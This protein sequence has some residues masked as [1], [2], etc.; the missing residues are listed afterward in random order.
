MSKLQQLKSDRQL[1]QVMHDFMSTYQQ[2]AAHQMETIRDQIIQGR[3][4]LEGLR[5]VFSDVNKSHRREIARLEQ[6]GKVEAAQQ[7]KIVTTTK[8][9][10]S[11]AVIISPDTKFSGGI[12]RRIFDSFKQHINQKNPDHIYVIGTVAR[13]FFVAT[14]P[15]KEF[16]E[17]HLPDSLSNL[18][19]LQPLLEELIQFEQVE[20]FYG[21]FLSLIRQEATHLDL[22]GGQTND[23]TAA[24]EAIPESTSYNRDF[25][26]EPAL[27]TMLRFFEVQIFSTLLLRSHHEAYLANLGARITTLDLARDSVG[28]RQKNTE[29]ALLQMK[30]NTKNKKRI[31]QLAGI[32]LW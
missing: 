28:K 27:E 30:K 19:L 12:N 7:L 8:N 25:I 23:Q 17:F 6:Q 16:K 3:R 20:V 22:V 32:Q 31:S 24:A 1:Y 18:E 13:E 21:Q 11:A 14:Y 10:L 9:G 5:Q 15:S 2:L 4:Y 26:F 29:S